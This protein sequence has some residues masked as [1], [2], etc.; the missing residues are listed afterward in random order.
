M[1]VYD[2]PVNFSGLHVPHFLIFLFSV[3][4]PDIAQ[5]SCPRP[6]SSISDLSIVPWL[7]GATLLVVGLVK[8]FKARKEPP[9]SDGQSSKEK[10][11]I[12]L[13]LGLL[14]FGLPVVAVFLFARFHDNS[15]Y[16]Y[17]GGVVGEICAAVLV[18]GLFGKRH[19]KIVAL[20]IA[21]ICIARFGY[22][23]YPAAKLELM[24]LMAKTGN[25]NAGFYAG[26][27]YSKV[28][29]PMEALNWYLLAAK[30]G[31]ARAQIRAGDLYREW[32]ETFSSMGRCGPEPESVTK[33]RSLRSNEEAMKWYQLAADA[34]N[35][36]AKGRL[37]SLYLQMA[38]HDAKYYPDALKWLREAAKQHDWSARAELG[39][40]YALGIGVEK[41]LKEAEK[42]SD[43]GKPRPIDWG[44]RLE[45]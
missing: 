9:H 13:L 32:D 33:V 37:G 21:V 23:I 16:H 25:A 26:E 15:I 1:G 5:A 39:R 31:D 17:D 34:G 11:K 19:F 35:V 22:G 44:D 4:L 45:P 27:H 10:A 12:L 42:W 14:L 18:I 6:S 38:A 24:V 43:Q 20:S 30:Q 29:D 40:M 28:R 3:L 41:N 2:C 36:A 8:L 7:L